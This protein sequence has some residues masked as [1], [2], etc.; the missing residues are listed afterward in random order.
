MNQN[1]QT[2]IRRG[3]HATPRRAGQTLLELVGA[4]TIIA[5]TLVPALRMMRDSLRVGRQTETANL[6][7]TFS[8][9]KLE[10]HL[11]RTAATWDTTGES[12]TIP[13][14]AGLRFQVDKVDE[15]IGAGLM[16]ITSLAWEDL[17]GDQSW[18]AGEARAVFS[19]K[20]AHNVSYQQE[21]HGP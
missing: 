16:R 9:S 19:S 13:G 17:N 10:E 11:V 4:T 7:A 8:A 2:P 20:L 1:R 21:A 14:Y 18:N 6:L 5:I 12:G 3:C 15:G